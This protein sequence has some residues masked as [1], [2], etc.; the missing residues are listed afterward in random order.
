MLHSNIDILHY[1]SKNIY[2]DIL[3]YFFNV[4]MS[5]KRRSYFSSV[6][7]WVFSFSISFCATY[8][9]KVGGIG[10]IFCERLQLS[11]ENG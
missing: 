10:A 5:K 11:V 1:L 4:L 7:I 8:F 2:I 3:H 9:S 6:F